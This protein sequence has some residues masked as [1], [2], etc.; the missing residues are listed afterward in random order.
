MTF[1]R[2]QTVQD[3]S[4]ESMA[5]LTIICREILDILDEEN[6]DSETVMRVRNLINCYVRANNLNVEAVQVVESG[7]GT[8]WI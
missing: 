4:K 1:K 3:I 2:N 7:R 6:G 8:F 5:S